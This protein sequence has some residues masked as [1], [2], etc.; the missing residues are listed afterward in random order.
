MAVWDLRIYKSWNVRNMKASWVNTYQINYDGGVE[1]DMWVQK[2]NSIATAEKNLSLNL[3]Q[4]LHATVSSKRDEAVYDPRMLR[5]FELTGNGLGTIP[6]DDPPL[7]LNIAFKVKKSVAFGRSG[8]MY[9]RGCLRQSDVDINDRG[10]SQWASAS[11]LNSPAVWTNLNTLW[12]AYPEM[13]IV[14]AGKDFDDPE[15]VTP[16]ETRAVQS[17]QGAGVVL[18]KRDHR[19]FDRRDPAP[20][21]A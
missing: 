16:L 1:D 3:V 8:S 18:L 7:D 17:F 6:E 15:L 11:H 2:I 12:S 20:V 13:Q 10:E 4:F 19:Y 5:T 14:M 21:P 9:F